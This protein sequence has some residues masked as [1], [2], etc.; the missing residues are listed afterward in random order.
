MT[1][2][3]ASDGGAKKMTVKSVAT[4]KEFLE[5]VHPNNFTHVKAALMEVRFQGRQQ[6]SKVLTIPELRLP[7]VTCKGERT[8]RRDGEHH[9]LSGKSPHQFFLT[10]TCSD[11]KEQHKTYA[12]RVQ[13]LDDANAALMFKFGERPSFGTAVPNAVLR[14]FGSD[15]DLFR[16]G[17]ECEKLGF[18]I[19]AFAYYRRVVESHKNEIFDWLIS[20][21]KKL[22]AEQ[23]MIDELTRLKADIQF[24]KA[25]GKIRAGIPAELLIQGQNPLLPLHGALSVGIHNE[26]DEDCLKAAQA[27]RVVL[28]KMAEKIASIREEDAQLAE[29]LKFLNEKRE[30]LPK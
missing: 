18:G 13:E 10:F 7:C 21:A 28:V 15:A 27:V 20:A 30:K 25:L 5:T 6:Y 22:G 16:K 9:S 17:Q 3:E 11:C 12:L 8:F 24:S 19:A 2:T 23:D 26:T 29:A 1:I 14:L 4:V